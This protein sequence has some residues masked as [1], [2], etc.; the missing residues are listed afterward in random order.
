MSLRVPAIERKAEENVSKWLHAE[1]SQKRLARLNRHN[2]HNNV[3]PYITLARETGAGGSELAKMVATR[4]QWDILDNEIVDYLEQHYGT[5]RCVIQQF[6]EKH[7]NWLSQILTSQISGLGFSEWTYTH[8]VSK[9]VLLAASHGNVVIVGRGA[10]FIL[11]RHHG[12]S[13]RVM[14]P[15]DFRVDQVIRQQG[16]SEKEAH[17]Y[18]VEKDRQRKNY[19]KEH[20]HQDTEDPHLYDVVINVDKVTLDAAATMIVDAASH[21][22]NKAA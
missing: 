20:F 18:I 13:V 19:I 10:R 2:L 22:L 1:H 9:L 11:P 5:P 4:M 21:W 17:Q 3:G 15:L 16:L 12:L 8:R 14:A 6:D 7:Q